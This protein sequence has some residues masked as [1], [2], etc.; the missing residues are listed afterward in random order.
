MSQLFVGLGLIYFVTVLVWFS[1]VGTPQKVVW[2]ITRTD[3]RALKMI[4][5]SLRS[6]F[7]W[8][9][10]ERRIS[11]DLHN[12]GRRFVEVLT[13]K[14]NT[15]TFNCWCVASWRGRRCDGR[16]RLSERYNV[17]GVEVKVL[18]LFMFWL[19]FMISELLNSAEFTRLHLLF[20][21]FSSLFC[22]FPLHFSKF[23]NFSFISFLFIWLETSLPA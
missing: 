17:F 14:T 9:T 4:Y 12:S 10:L 20:F 23:L 13:L 2:T 16:W 8:R 11:R 5:C 21:W 6:D 18:Q 19:S 1:R 15:L 7:I 22:P 3:N